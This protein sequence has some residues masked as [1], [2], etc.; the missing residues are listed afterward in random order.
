MALGLA[1]VFCATLCAPAFGYIDGGT[2]SMI[3]QI[4]ISG[5]LGA[6]FFARS[7]IARVSQVFTRKGE[8]KS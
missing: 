8:P 2:G 6:L 3:M 5:L 4:A 1:I 7:A